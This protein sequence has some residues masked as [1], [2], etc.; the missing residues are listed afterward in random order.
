MSSAV[1]SLGR[2]RK[3]CVCFLMFF[4]PCKI[5]EVP[6]CNV[7]QNRLVLCFRWGGELVTRGFSYFN[8]II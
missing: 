1:E 8:H 3:C 4:A 7:G 5:V 6:F 2:R